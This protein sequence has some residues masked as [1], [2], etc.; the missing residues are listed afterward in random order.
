MVFPSEAGNNCSC[1][2]IWAYIGSTG[3]FPEGSEE[4]KLALQGRA[5]LPKAE[6]ETLISQGKATDEDLF[7]NQIASVQD[8]IPSVVV[9][10]AFPLITFF[11]E[12]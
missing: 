2:W 10:L 1:L 11:S 4:Y 7:V 5:V 9:P 6:M 8:I 3:I 12:S